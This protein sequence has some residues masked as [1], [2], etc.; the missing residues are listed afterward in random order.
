MQES[1]SVSIDA[2]QLHLFDVPHDALYRG[3][4]RGLSQQGGRVQERGRLVL[5]CAGA[6]PVG[7]VLVAGVPLEL[8]GVGFLLLRLELRVLLRVLLLRLVHGAEELLLL[9][10]RHGGRGQWGCRLG[11]RR[12]KAGAAA[13]GGNL[14]AG[15][16]QRGD[17]WTGGKLLRH[18]LGGS[19]GCSEVIKVLLGKRRILERVE[20]V[21]QW[22]DARGWRDCLI[23]PGC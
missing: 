22:E 19:G 4:F 18:I 17:G 6:L 12:G 23:A 1:S 9:R 21:V 14:G 15:G 16:L 13:V 7:L 3:A 10:G 5:G 11:R 8:V 2:L 20:R